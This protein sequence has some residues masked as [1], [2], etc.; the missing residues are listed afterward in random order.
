MLCLF[1]G[2][3]VRTE[4]SAVRTGSLF[5]GVSLHMDKIINHAIKNEH[6][7]RD[8]RNQLNKAMKHERMD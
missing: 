4:T 8:S 7:C 3:L 2:W 1:R 5:M 6:T